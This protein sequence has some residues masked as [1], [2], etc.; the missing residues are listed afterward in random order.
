[1]TLLTTNLIAEDYRFPIDT[2][3]QTLNYISIDTSDV[4][5]RPDWVDRDSF[6]LNLVDKFM[7]RPLGIPDFLKSSGDYLLDSANSVRQKLQHLQ[8][9]LIPEGGAV[10]IDSIKWESRTEK[11]FV[12]FVKTRSSCDSLAY[13]LSETIKALAGMGNLAQLRRFAPEE[14]RF[15]IDSFTVFLKEEEKDVNRPLEELDEIQKHQESMAIR[16]KQVTDLRN[17]RDLVTNA[18][19][20]KAYE[21]LVSWLTR[22]PDLIERLVHCDLL[23]KFKDVQ[24]PLG[25][26]AVRGTGN[27]HY[28]GFYDLIIDLGGDDEYYLSRSEDFHNQII[29]DLTGNDKYFAL[30]D[31]VMG[32][33]FFST[34]ILDDWSGNDIYIANKFS[35]GCGFFG[36]GILI[37]RAGD[38][39]YCGDI[40]CQAASSFGVGMLLDYA[41]R[42]TYTSALYSQGFGFIM[43]ASALVD[44]SGNDTYA[45]GWKYG[46]ILRYEDH[47]VSL[48]QGFGYGL[49]PYFSGG[50]GLLIDGAGN[51]QYSADIFGQGASYWFA[52]GGLIDYGGN[53]NY[54]AYQYAQ[55]A[56]THMC[57]ATLIDISGEDLYSSKGVSQGC[58]HDIAFGLLLDCNGNDQYSATDLSQAAGSANGIGM[59][60]D[61]R[62]DDG[63]MARVQLNT[64][65]YGNPRREFG[66]IGLFLDL[67]G[68][69]AYRG[70]G[71]DNTYW[72]SPSKW[73]IGA[74]LNSEV[75]K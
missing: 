10:A 74:D 51:D 61:L 29:I 11:Y 32:A 30:S 25:R 26:I 64:H 54:I 67:Q 73:G 18:L 3:N 56:A 6:R 50:I 15:F 45:A 47:Y 40:A 20:L 36:T 4:G 53:D 57:V 2:I 72:V 68:L 52:L 37:D 49:R 35:Q 13:Y 60:I 65:G 48:S 63:H 69:D 8:L 62:G 75:K 17:P 55:G 71:Q 24:T 14:Q 70:Y 22:N 34:G 43:G 7:R 39:L 23:S 31:H 9:T 38:D 42:D 41:G 59:L 5:F 19:P 44:N 33:G 46:D 58:G 1:M 28:E 66:S 21:D 16:L 27:D 12:D